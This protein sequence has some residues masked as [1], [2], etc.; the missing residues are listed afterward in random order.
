VLPEEGIDIVLTVEP[1]VHHQLHLFQIQEI[2]IRQQ[3]VYRFD[4]RDV[5]RQFA[6]IDRQSGVFAEEQGQINL[7]E[8][9]IFFVQ[10][11]FDLFE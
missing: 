10:T 7:G 11:V 8:S 9:V 2:N 3:V 1:P 5:S 4:I 6:V